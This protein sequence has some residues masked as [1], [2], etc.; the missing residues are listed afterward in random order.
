MIEHERAVR[1]YEIKYLF[2]NMYQHCF[3]KKKKKNN[4]KVCM[5]STA[6]ML[7]QH[8]ECNWLLY[9]LDMQLMTY[10]HNYKTNSSL[11]FDF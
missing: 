1:Q 2:G 8:T 5:D 9:I 7:Y 4:V 3:E 10:T 6:S 11:S